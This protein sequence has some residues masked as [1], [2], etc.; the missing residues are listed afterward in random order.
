MYG[1]VVIGWY[2]R[3]CGN[4]HQDLQPFYSHAFHPPPLQKKKIMY[5]P[6]SWLAHGFRRAGFNDFNNDFFIDLDLACITTDYET[7]SHGMM[8]QSTVVCVCVCVSRS[9]VGGGA[10]VDREV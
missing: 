3:P 5:F 1:S 9:V 8:H 10:G 6:C 7:H 2:S 4:T